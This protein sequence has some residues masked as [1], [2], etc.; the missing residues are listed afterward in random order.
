[1]WA[2]EEKSEPNLRNLCWC[3]PMA[4][5]WVYL[6]PVTSK[7]TLVTE[8]AFFPEPRS[9]ST[10]FQGMLSSPPWISIW[11]GIPSIGYPVPR[12]NNRNSVIAFETSYGRCWKISNSPT[13]LPRTGAVLTKTQILKK[14]H[15]YRGLK[16]SFWHRHTGTIRFWFS[17][18]AAYKTLNSPLGLSPLTMERNV[19][20]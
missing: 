11:H 6:L 1:M 17:K 16:Y 2:Y 4:G 7:G 5:G 3:F 12:L 20:N 13:Q 18:P 10:P 14:T 9:L 19:K 8:V 15:L